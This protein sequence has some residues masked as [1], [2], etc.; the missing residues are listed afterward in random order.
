MKEPKLHCPLTFAVKAISGKWKLF[1]LSVL[2]NGDTKRYGEIKRDCENITEKMLTSQLRELENDDIIN[3]K[4]YA[5]VPPKV[6]YSLTERGK[7][8]C[9]IFDPL[10]EWGVDYIKDIKPDQA[11]LLNQKKSETS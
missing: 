6:E 11:Y 8:L 7:K 1:I 10:Y 4:V 5:E 9:L 2:S 3:R